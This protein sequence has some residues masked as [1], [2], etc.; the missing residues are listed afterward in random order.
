[1]LSEGEVLGEVMDRIRLRG[2]GPTRE[3]QRLCKENG[4]LGEERTPW[5]PHA[6]LQALHLHLPPQNQASAALDSEAP[7]ADS[8]LPP[9]RC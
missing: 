6:R 7:T 1:M 3:S 2:W 9:S 4:G 8:H 5:L